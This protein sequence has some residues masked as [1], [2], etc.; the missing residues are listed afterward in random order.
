M[1]ELMLRALVPD[2]FQQAA[3]TGANMPVVGLPQC[4]SFGWELDT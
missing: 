3:V 2:T 4:H 1:P